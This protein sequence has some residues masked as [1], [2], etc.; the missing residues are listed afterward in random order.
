MQVSCTCFITALDGLRGPVQE[1]RTMKQAEK[2]LRGRI[3]VLG[4]LDAVD[5]RTRHNRNAFHLSHMHFCN[6]DYVMQKFRN[7]TCMTS[8]RRESSRVSVACMFKE[9]SFRNFL[10]IIDCAI[11]PRVIN[12]KC[13]LDN[14]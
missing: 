2:Q 10:C 7:Y 4:Q 8:W 13:N 12:W 3:W 5:R 11:L 9:K 1:L 14:F 6:L